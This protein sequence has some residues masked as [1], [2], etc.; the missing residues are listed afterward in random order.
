MPNES[1]FAPAGPA[2]MQ[3]R[4]GDRPI[5]QLA[6]RQHGVV[7]RRQLLGLGFGRHAISHRIETGRLHRLQS[8]VYAVGHKALSSESR[9]MAGVLAGGDET[10]LSHRSAATLWG[11]RKHLQPTIEVTSPRSTRS[12]PSLRRHCAQLRRDEVTSRRGIPVTT[13]S[14][15]LFDL[16]AAVSAPDFERSMR[17]A[18]VLRLPL[19]PSL[20]ELLIRHPRRRGTGMVRATL[21]RLSLLPGGVTRSPLEDRFLRFAAAAGLPMPETNVVLEIDGQTYEADCLWRE[22]RLILELDGHEVHGTRAAFENDRERDRRLQAA[23]WT[24]I[25][26]THRQLTE[27]QGL[28]RDLHRLLHAPSPD[29]S[30]YRPARAA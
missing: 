26:A 20:Q 1:A 30:A 16:A 5:S 23:G 25:R 2:Q 29:E 6:G 18:E 21:E 14:R 13:V 12:T 7:S 22:R 17:E 28:T 3:I 9:W 11:L 8:G 4:V 10:V 15:T 19:R 27:D 24:V